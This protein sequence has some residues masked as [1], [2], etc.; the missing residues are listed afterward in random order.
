[1]AQSVFIFYK[2]TRGQPSSRHHK[3]KTQHNI[4]QSL[5]HIFPFPLLVPPT[6]L[7]SSQKTQQLT[8]PPFPGSAQPPITCSMDS[9]ALPS[10]PSLAVW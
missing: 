6:P 9:Q 5:P 7:T 1:M 3:H 4:K 10:L 2:G 8:L